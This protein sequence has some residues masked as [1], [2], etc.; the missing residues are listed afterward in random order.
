[1]ILPCDYRLRQREFEY[2]ESDNN[3]AGYSLDYHDISVRKYKLM[4]WKT[5]REILKIAGYDISSLENELVFDHSKGGK[6]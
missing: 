1:M 5:V 6:I 4:L 2:Y 3:K